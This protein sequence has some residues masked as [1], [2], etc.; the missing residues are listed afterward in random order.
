MKSKSQIQSE[1]QI[2][3]NTE[4]ERAED[5]RDIYSKREVLQIIERF[6][7]KN[8]EIDWDAPQ[9]NE[10]D[11]TIIKGKCVDEVTKLIE[12]FD[13]DVD[14]NLSCDGENKIETEVQTSHICAEVID[15]IEE[16]FDELEEQLNADRQMK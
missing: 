15:S 14:V 5:G 2:L 13:Y 16:W 8:D 3:I 4:R 9:H 7:A 11:L 6:Q 10:F 12:N 1:I